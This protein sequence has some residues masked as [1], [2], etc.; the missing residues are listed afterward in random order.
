MLIPPLDG[1]YNLPDHILTQARNKF[2][3]EELNI[4]DRW[5]GEVIHDGVTLPEHVGF[6]ACA[7][8][9]IRGL[10]AITSPQVNVLRYAGWGRW[11]TREGAAQFEVEEK[12]RRR[13]GES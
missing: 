6:V 1:L 9:V 3:I 10:L 2:R 7:W 13:R 4:V 8:N 11:C 5:G 12:G